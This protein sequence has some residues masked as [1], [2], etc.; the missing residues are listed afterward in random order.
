MCVC[1]EGVA[2]VGSNSQSEIIFQFFAENCVGMK[3]F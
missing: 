2:A 3:E 1:G